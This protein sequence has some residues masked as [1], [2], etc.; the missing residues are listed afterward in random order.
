M[1]E[2]KQQILVKTHKPAFSYCVDL[3]FYKTGQWPL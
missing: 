2:I 1:L 3:Q